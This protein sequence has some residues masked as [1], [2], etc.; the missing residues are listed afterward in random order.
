MARI[1]YGVS[2]EGFGHS[3]RAREIAR[4]LLATGH[5]VHLVSYDRGVQALRDDFSVFETVGLRIAASDNKVS[6]GKTL[7]ENFRQLPEG[8]QKFRELK[9]ELFREF[10]PHCVLTDFEPMTAYLAL[11]H[12]LPLVS[13]DNQHRMRYMEYEC[14]AHLDTDR[15]ITENVIRAIVPKPDVCLV[16]TFYFG[17]TTNERTFLFPPILRQPVRDVEPSPGTKIL[18]YLTRGFETFLSHLSRFPRE[19]F[20]VYGSD[21]GPRSSNL[22]Y[23][24]F[25]K[26]GFLEDLAAAKAVFATAGFTL[27]SEALFLRKP[28][29]AV[30]MQGQFEQ[31]LNGLLLEDMGCGKNVRDVRE[32]AVGDFLYR[33][34]EYQARLAEYDAGDG[35][36]I[37]RKLDTLLENDAS[38]ARRLAEQRRQ[39]PSS[40][41]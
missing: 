38:E 18:V 17:P 31:Q 24:P 10:R 16:T 14:P 22:E 29:L 32:E 11:H 3:S 4:H 39:E 7:K 40:A 36:A 23:R 1:V 25:S 19:Q 15:R 13:I 5:D 30:P 34:P 35:K 26:D 12:R 21:T 20:L 28:I 8:Y 37:F 27:M 9:R 41:T 2:G 33:L 6:I